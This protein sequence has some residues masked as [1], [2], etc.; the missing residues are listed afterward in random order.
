[1]FK[2]KTINCFLFLFEKKK[3]LLLW[4]RKKTSHL[5]PLFDFFERA[6]YSF[7][8][9][10]VFLFF[11][12]FIE[13][14]CLLILTLPFFCS[15]HCFHIQKTFST[16]S[17]LECLLCL[18]IFPLVLP[19]SICSLFLSL[20]VFSLLSPCRPFL[21][22]LFSLSFVVS[23]FSQPKPFSQKFCFVLQKL[24]FSVFF[25]FTLKIILSV[26]FFVGLLFYICL[27]VFC[28]FFVSWKLVSRLCCDSPSWFSFFILFFFLKKK[29]VPFY[30]LALMY[31]KRCRFFPKKERYILLF[32][33]FFLFFFFSS[34]VF[35]KIFLCVK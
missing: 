14:L 1:M 17:L 6:K 30:S 9:F 32:F 20:G 2:K 23:L 31:L 24:S 19:K 29:V 5:F 10:S 15:L 28:F 27:S 8:F 22:F 26:S 35:F 11:F 21:N 34:L 18:F 3:L 4:K 13:N 25:Y 7:V 16:L 12:F 33:L